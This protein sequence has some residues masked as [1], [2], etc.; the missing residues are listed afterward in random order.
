LNH[1]RLAISGP[2]HQDRASFLFFAALLSLA[3]GTAVASEHDTLT[4]APLPS[5]FKT[6]DPSYQVSVE[7]GT[8]TMKDGT[9]LA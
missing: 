9:P 5:W 2:L 8:L 7:T 4:G 3:A 6:Y 1:A